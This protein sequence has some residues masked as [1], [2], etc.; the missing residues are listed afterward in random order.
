[1]TRAGIA[2]A[3]LGNQFIHRAIGLNADVVFVDTAAAKQCGRAFIAGSGVDAVHLFYLAEGKRFDQLTSI[4][5]E[6]A[7]PGCTGVDMTTDQRLILGQLG[8]G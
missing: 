7:E 6:D 8:V 1:M 5:T 2:D 3:K 4:S